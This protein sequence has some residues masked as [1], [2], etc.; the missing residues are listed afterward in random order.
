MCQYVGR[1]CIKY[2]STFASK[3]PPYC[4]IVQHQDKTLDNKFM[5]N[6]LLAVLDHHLSMLRK[7]KQLSVCLTFRGTC[8]IMSS[9]EWSR[10]PTQV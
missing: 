5:G 10:A 8:S 1:S 7:V 9:L 4:V 2:L 3:A 6:T